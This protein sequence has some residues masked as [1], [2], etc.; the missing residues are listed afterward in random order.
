MNKPSQ[1]GDFLK[2]DKANPMQMQTLSP[3]DFLNKHYIYRYED[4]VQLMSTNID[5]GE[6]FDNLL[7]LHYSFIVPR[8]HLLTSEELTEYNIDEIIKTKDINK[9][10][11]L[12]ESIGKKMHKMGISR[13]EKK[14]SDIDHIAIEELE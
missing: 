13:T 1:A 10:L 8:K 4:V 11:L 12:L 7:K 3:R 14:E 2:M 9:G 6:F 5:R